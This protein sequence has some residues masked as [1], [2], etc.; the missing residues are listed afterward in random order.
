MVNKITSKKTHKT[1]RW[2]YSLAHDTTISAIKSIN[3]SI[4]DFILSWAVNHISDSL[5]NNNPTNL[6]E[7]TKY[8]NGHT[9]DFNARATNSP[10]NH[11][12]ITFFVLFLRIHKGQV[13]MRVH[14]VFST[15]N[16]CFGDVQ[17][18]FWDNAFFSKLVRSM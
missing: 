1:L 8:A 10:R 15:I 5:R 13:K 3:N 4:R 7:T 12:N 6:Y 9:K 11:T 18:I 14:S 2:I 16:H 17:G